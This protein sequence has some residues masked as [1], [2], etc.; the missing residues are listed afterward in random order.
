MKIEGKE[1]QDYAALWGSTESEYGRAMYDVSSENKVKDRAFWCTF[2]GAVLNLHR[3]ATTK[4]KGFDPQDAPNLW[5]L[6]QWA[7]EQ[8]VAANP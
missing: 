8:Y 7:S 4:P 1:P 5:K 2:I 6:Y 3:D